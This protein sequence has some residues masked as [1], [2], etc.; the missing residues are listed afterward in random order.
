MGNA[1]PPLGKVFKY[2]HLPTTL[3]LRGVGSNPRKGFFFLSFFLLFIIIY[4]SSLM[5]E[6]MF[7]K[8]KTTL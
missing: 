8:I 5:K 4:V 6:K 2:N 1:L 3:K 7:D